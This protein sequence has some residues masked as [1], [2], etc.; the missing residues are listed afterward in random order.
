M[1]GI[2]Q[3]LLSIAA[4][5]VLALAIG[6]LFMLPAVFALQ[7]THSIAN[8]IPGFSEIY[9]W[10]YNNNIL[11]YAS[12]ILGNLVAFTNPTDKEGLP[13]IYCGFV[14]VLLGAFFFRCKKSH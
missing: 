13:N 6:A 12:D 3:K 11:Q 8:A 9:D 14:C 2:F 5:S 7:N 1:E 10:N 4:F